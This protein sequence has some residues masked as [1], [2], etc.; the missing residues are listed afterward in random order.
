MLIRLTSEAAAEGSF[1]SMA[2]VL[3]LRVVAL[4]G[5]RKE[6]S[7]GSRAES[8]SGAHRHVGTEWLEEASTEGRWRLL[9]AVYAAQMHREHGGVGGIGVLCSRPHM[10]PTV[11]KAS[12]AP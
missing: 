10:R 1:S 4:R 11:M 8:P 6:R 12:P 7:M 9:T 5:R 2:A 3:G